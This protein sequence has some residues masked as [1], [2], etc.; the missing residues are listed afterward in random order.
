MKHRFFSPTQMI[1][2][3][4]A[5]KAYGEKICSFGKK[6]MIVTSKTAAKVTGALSDVEGVLKGGNIPYEIFSEVEQ[7]PSYN[8]VSLAADLAVKSGCDFFIGIGGGSAMDAAK[9]V[10]LLCANPEIS[11]EDAFSLNI[12]NDPYPI[13]C[14]GTTA[15]TGSE[16]TEYSVITGT[17]GKKKSIGTEKI[18][19]VLSLGDITYIKKMSSKVLKSTA[20][21]AMCHAFESYFNKKSDSFSNTFSIEALK[22]LIPEFETISAYGSDGLDDLDFEN[23]YLASIY[24]GYAIATT[25]TAFCHGLSYYLSENFSVPHGFACG[26][27]LPAFL[28]HNSK[29][30]KEKSARLY[31]ELCRTEYE[32]RTLVSDLNEAGEISFTEKDLEILRPR[33]KN[34]KSLEKCLGE[35]TPEYAEE[36][37]KALFM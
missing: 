27:F 7:N 24:A 15:G 34:N 11:E 18:L 12:S 21:D 23:L 9:A 33:L 30:A 5:V 26:V 32:I 14:I 35:C 13:I 37:L 20:I 4:D 17:D 29:W 22:L 28:M 1:V 25:G 36:I 3:K 31:D 10:S 16:V 2:Q 19:P 6:A 8:T